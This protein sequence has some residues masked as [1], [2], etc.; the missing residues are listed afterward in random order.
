VFQQV[1]GVHREDVQ[2]L[3][4]EGAAGVQHPKQATAKG[5]RMKLLLLVALL[6]PA[7]AVNPSTGFEMEH[8]YPDGSIVR[9]KLDR[10]WQEG[11]FEAS[12]EL[13]PVNGRWVVKVKSLVDL[14]PAVEASKAQAKAQTEIAGKL[15][16]LVRLI[17]SGAG[18]PVVPAKVE[19][20]P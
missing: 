11:S 14:G 13:D 1:Q 9:V 8:E 4:R 16:D 17:A 5:D 20:T 12:A 7:C 2:K 3:V 19:A 6:L 10:A 15:A 18:V